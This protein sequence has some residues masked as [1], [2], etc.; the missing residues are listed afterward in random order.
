M[1]DT[2]TNAVVA[3]H[4]LLDEHIPLEHDERQHRDRHEHHERRDIKQD[5]D[6]GHDGLLVF[7]VSDVRL[8]AGACC[9]ASKACH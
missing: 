1:V 5:R 7:V 9:V 6:A 4:A 2:G 3:I 8:S